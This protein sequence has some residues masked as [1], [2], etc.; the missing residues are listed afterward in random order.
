MLSEC[1]LPPH[2][3]IILNPRSLKKFKIDIGEMEDT[4]HTHPH[5]ESLFPSLTPFSESQLAASLFLG[6]LY[7]FP[8]QR[9]ILLLKW[10]ENSFRHTIVVC[11]SVLSGI[12]FKTGKIYLKLSSHSLCTVKKSL[13]YLIFCFLTSLTGFIP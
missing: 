9:R 6:V 12:V 7:T 11:C 4:A 1:C 13:C 3:F 5:H 2:L 10:R 8:P